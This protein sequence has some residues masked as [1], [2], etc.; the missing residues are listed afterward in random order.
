MARRDVNVF[1]ILDAQLADVSDSD[2]TLQKE[3]IRH[4]I[5]LCRTV[6]P[7]AP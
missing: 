3:G 5:K 6:E 2:T 7:G 1:E 4:G